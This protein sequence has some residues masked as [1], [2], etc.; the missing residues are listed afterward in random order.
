MNTCDVRRATCGVK[1]AHRL[2]HITLILVIF[3][4]ALISAASGQDTVCIQCHGSLPGR[5]GEPVKLWRQSIHAS[6]GI[7]C[8]NCHGG[9][10]SD[11][12]AAMSPARGFLGKPKEMEIPGFC[13]RCHIGVKEDYLDSAHGRALGRGG[14]QCVTCHSNHH[15]VAATPDL[16][17]PQDC[18][19]CHAYGQAGEIKSAV[20]STDGM[21]IGLENRLS[22]LYRLGIDT[23]AI[24]GELFS[25]RNRFHR[26]FHTVNV[27]KV[28]SQTAGF[29]AG[30]AK[31]SGQVDSIEAELGNRKAHG[32]IAIVLFVCGG[33][34][35]LLINRT[36]R[37]KDRG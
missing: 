10:P 22:G 31:I 37:D 27:E 13:G 36:Y 19:R 29:Q 1:T 16:I 20:A 30:L 2:R 14:P 8:N 3:N 15:V 33:I 35:A 4:F 23:T 32:G 5:L 7:S 12:S 21:I 9:D 17:N 34:L 28:R 6:N 24:N 26:I 18:A 25:L 11:M